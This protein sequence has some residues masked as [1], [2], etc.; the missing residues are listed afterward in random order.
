VNDLRL[1]KK[2]L[3]K[4]KVEVNKDD[5]LCD[6]MEYNFRNYI[7]QKHWFVGI[8]AVTGAFVFGYVVTSCTLIVGLPIA[9]FTLN[10]TLKNFIKFPKEKFEKI[11]VDYQNHSKK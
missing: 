2:E 5:I 6:T 7:S 3:F 1:V 10:R 9:S 11:I 8:V 4:R